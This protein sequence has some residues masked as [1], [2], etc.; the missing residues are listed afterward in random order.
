MTTPSPVAPVEHA[1]PLCFHQSSPDYPTRQLGTNA[2]A[3]EDCVITSLKRVLLGVNSLSKAA[4]FV[5]LFQQ[6]VRDIHM[7]IV[8]RV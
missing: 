1:K 4:D 6:F 2:D 7:V 8:H 5:D 3:Q